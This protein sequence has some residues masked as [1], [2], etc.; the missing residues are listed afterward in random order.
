MCPRVEDKPHAH[1]HDANGNGSSGNNGN[2]ATKHG[3]NG[4]N[5]NGDSTT[6][7]EQH[8]LVNTAEGKAPPTN[9]QETIKA[10]SECSTA[11]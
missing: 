8:A 1:K 4:S 6:L 5:G 11:H 3:H 2:S 9:N 7:A 10:G